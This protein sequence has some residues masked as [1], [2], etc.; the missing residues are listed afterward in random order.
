MGKDSWKHKVHGVIDQRL[1]ANGYIAVMGFLKAFG[2]QHQTSLHHLTTMLS[3]ENEIVNGH[4]KMAVLLCRT[5]EAEALELLAFMCQTVQFMNTEEKFLELLELM[6]ENPFSPQ[7]S[8][9]LT[10]AIANQAGGKE[11]VSNLLKGLSSEEEDEAS[12]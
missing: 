5:N 7:V 2:E 3:W 8:D 1:T 9:F 10:K 12:N 6:K 4:V 11:W